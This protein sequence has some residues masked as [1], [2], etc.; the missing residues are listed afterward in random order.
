MQ[1]GLCSWGVA[2]ELDLVVSHF[3]AALVSMVIPGVMTELINLAISKFMDTNISQ[4][5][6]GT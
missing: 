6:S 5:Y 2:R 4:S 1:L 3:I